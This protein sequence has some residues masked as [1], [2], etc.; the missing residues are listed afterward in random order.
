MYKKWDN[1]KIE[2]VSH[3]WAEYFIVK[4][5]EKIEETLDEDFSMTGAM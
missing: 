4:S 2:T 1:I 5:F 3:K